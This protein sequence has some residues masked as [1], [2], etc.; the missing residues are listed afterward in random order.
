MAEIRLQS[1]RVGALVGKLKAAGVPEHVRAGLE[2]KLGR[3]TQPSHHLAPPRSREGRAA[4]GR[5]HE[6]RRRLLVAAAKGG[7]YVAAL[8][9]GTPEF[10]ILCRSDVLERHSKMVFIKLI[11]FDLQSTLMNRQT[12]G[13]WYVFFAHYRALLPKRNNEYPNVFSLLF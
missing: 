6:R 3:D 1:A 8:R 7:R 4:L 10:S 13:A 11:M 5:E 12:Q 9:A 2:A